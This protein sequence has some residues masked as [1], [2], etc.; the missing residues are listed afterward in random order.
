MAC[1]APRRELLRPFA[2][3]S[4]PQCPVAVFRQTSSP[5]L[6]T[7]LA[8]LRERIF[9]PAHLPKT[10]KD[11]IYQSKHHHLLE[12]ESVTATLG[13]ETHILRPINR[14]KDEPR[15]RTAFHYIISLMREPSDWDNLVPLL[16]EIRIAKRRLPI[17]TLERTVRRASQTRRWD[18]LLAAARSPKTTGFELRDRKLVL[19]VLWGLRE[20]V[21]AASWEDAT[22]DST[23]RRAE[24]VCA[25]LD[26]KEHCGG[27]Q[28]SSSDPRVRP[29]VVGVLLELAAVRALRRY[30][31]KDE[32]GMVALYV[33]RLEGVWWNLDLADMK[34]WKRENARLWAWVPVWNGLRL[35]ER[36]LGPHERVGW[37][38]KARDEVSKYVEKDRDTVR[39]EAEE[40]RVPKGLRWL[41]DAEKL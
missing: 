29:E 14:T 25:L 21:M 7:A 35:A 30:G 36:I 3:L 9:V 23:L 15:T 26:D 32:D 5:E 33:E 17:E 39:H 40:G 4:A 24:A 16:E 38:S 31:G 13:D 41:E 12:S 6:D 19:Q 10:S 8:N 22:T 34:E 27:Q 37:V 28:I 1:K 20:E 11:L 2:A 18:T